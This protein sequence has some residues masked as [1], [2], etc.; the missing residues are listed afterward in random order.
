MAFTAATVAIVVT[1]GAAI[2]PY[3]VLF[4]VWGPMRAFVETVKN[5]M[6]Q[7]SKVEEEES[8]PTTIDI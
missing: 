2:F 5:S 4:V 1:R 3:F 6:H 7:A 8:E